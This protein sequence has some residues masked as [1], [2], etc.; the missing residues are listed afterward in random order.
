MSAFDN[1]V[2]T[3]VTENVC[4][5]AARRYADKAVR[6]MRLCPGAACSVAAPPSAVS[7]SKIVVCCNFILSILMRLSEPSLCASSSTKPG[8]FV[9]MCT[10]TISSSSMTSL[11]SPF[12]SMTSLNRFTFTFV[13]FLSIIN[14][15]Q[16]ANLIFSVSM[17]ACA[18]A[19]VVFL[20]LLSGRR[21][22]LSIGRGTLPSKIFTK[23]A[24]PASDQRPLHLK[25]GRRFG[26]LSSAAFAS[27]IACCMMRTISSSISA[28]FTAEAA[29]SRATVRIVPSV[30]RIT[31]L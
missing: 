27:S 11:Q 19:E 9:W 15:V 1:F 18:V 10:F 23:P 6:L 31:A 21:A 25:T 30:G 24:P 29:H 14:S 26:V 2:R 17:A 20:P 13:D 4:K 8:L 22:S 3:I 16:Y 12:G 5:A 7:D 28:D